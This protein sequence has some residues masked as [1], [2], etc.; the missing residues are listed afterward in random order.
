MN[1]FNDFWN[2]FICFRVLAL[3]VKNPD[4]IN[5]RDVTVAV[6]VVGFFVINATLFLLLPRVLIIFPLNN[7]I[8]KKT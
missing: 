5:P 6:K 7:Y 2:V 1:P 4:S 8:R 3:Y